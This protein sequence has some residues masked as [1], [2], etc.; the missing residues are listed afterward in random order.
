MTHS[1]GGATSDYST[2]VLATKAVDFI[3]GLVGTAV[4]PL[5]R[6]PSAAQPVQRTHTPR[7][8][9]TR[10]APM[11]ARPPST[12]PN[13]AEADVSDKPEWVQNRPLPNVG[14]ERA[15]RKHQCE[16]LLALDDDVQSIFTALRTRA[17]STTRSSST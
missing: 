1:F 15:H 13:F 16:M 4:L 7:T 8:R 5:L 10:R 12:G 14:D 17:C 9:T 3:N 6:T 11:S 2:D